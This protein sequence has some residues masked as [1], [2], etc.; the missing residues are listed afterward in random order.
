MKL[1]KFKQNNCTPCKMLEDILTDNDIKVDQTVN[2]T[3]PESDEDLMLAGMHGIDKTPVLLLLDDNGKEI[4]R[5]K[6][7][8]A[9][10]IKRVLS[11]RGL[12]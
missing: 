2:L 4:D 7:V 11:K 3:E 9:T 12:I 1:V 10:G 5:H 6:G 8:G